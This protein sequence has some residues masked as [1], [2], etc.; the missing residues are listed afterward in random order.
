MKPNKVR[1]GQIWRFQDDVWKYDFEIIG[2]SGGR[3]EYECRVREI[4]RRD[5]RNEEWKVGEEF[6]VLEKDL[7][8]DEEYR[9]VG[10]G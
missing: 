3:Y 6:V 4:E 2:K 8:E 9:Y 1:V 5:P 7:L 10:V